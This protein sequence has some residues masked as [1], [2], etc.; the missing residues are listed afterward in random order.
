MSSEFEEIDDAVIA[1]GGVGEGTTNDY[2]RVWGSLIAARD[3]Q[4]NITAMVVDA[5]RGGLV[6][7]VGMRGFIPKSQIATRNLNNLERYIGQTVEARI[8]DVDQEKGRVVLSERKVAE[9]K[10]A[11]ERA[12]TI[13]RLS[14]GQVVDGVV[15]RLTEFGAFVDIGGVD[16]LLHISDMSWEPISKPTDLLNVDDT[17]QVM[18][19][20]I[21]RGGE[22]I[23]LG[24]KQLE[25][26]PWTVARKE[27]K[28]GQIIDVTITRIQP[29]G[30]F[31]R[32]M[33]GVE[34]LIPVKELSDRRVENPESVVQ[35]GQT[36]TVKITEFY[37]R[38][39]R[40]SLSIRQVARDRERQELR[41]YEKRQ[42]SE[43]AAPTLGDLFGDV[44]SKLK[45]DE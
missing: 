7:D 37:P 27:L 11:L 45:K 23:A 1:E 16:G 30:A 18:I 40:M 31:A 35:V 17:I 15:R 26:D 10:R 41:D 42:K 24:L 38:D 34:G 6:V 29:F 9:E 5:V 8:V 39:G 22:R 13:S 32:V 14:K 19:L 36:V 25:D 3:A 20:K 2:D 43:H 33:K 44:F 28:D 4:T 12:E 21:E